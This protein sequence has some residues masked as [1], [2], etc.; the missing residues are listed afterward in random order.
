MKVLGNAGLTRTDKALIL[1][2]SQ[3]KTPCGNDQWIR[4]T[5]D[6]VQWLIESGYTLI[7]S[8]GLNTWEIIVYLVSKHKGNQLIICPFTGE[9]DESFIYSDIVESFKLEPDR[10]A[11]VSIEKEQGTA[12]GKKGWFSRDMAAVDLANII[13]PVSIR[14]KGKLEKLIEK[15]GG[16]RAIDTRFNV[17][18]RRPTV[19]PPRY[20]GR[21]LK[22]N[23]EKWDHVTH[24]TRTRHGPWP[25]QL[26]FDYY[27]SITKSESEYPNNAFNT[28]V[29]IAR[30]RI[31]RGSSQRIREGRRVIGFTESHPE[32]TLRRIRWLPK[33]VNWNFEPYAVAINKRKAADLGIKPVIYGDSGDYSSLD[34]DKKPYFQSRGRKNVDWSEEK[35]WRYPG[36]LDLNRIDRDDLIYIVLNEPEKRILR[37]IADNDII[38]IV[39][40]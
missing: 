8:T 37:K 24:W 3:S 2:S 16:D 13:V 14:P 22:I 4:A 7:S 25:G 11:M 36:D 29:N 30:E 6:A 19:S 35:E 21:D 23:L 27:G 17:E 18:Y 39:G 40:E 28:L 9:S 12:G 20:S 33:R 34:N 5:S 32:E 26:E 15:A 10:T 38:A 31:L 1:N